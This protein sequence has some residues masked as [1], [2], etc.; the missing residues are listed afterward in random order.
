[1]TKLRN[2]NNGDSNPGSLDCE[3]GIPPTELPFSTND[4]VQ[5][6]GTSLLTS[7]MELI[8]S[9]P[10]VN[11][12]ILSGLNVLFFALWKLILGLGKGDP[13]LE[14]TLSVR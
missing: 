11:V 2:G 8:K 14:V 10:N 3:S 13:I 6:N 9:D 5:H 7:P 4:N 1:M 12:T